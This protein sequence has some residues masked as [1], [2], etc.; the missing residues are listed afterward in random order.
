LALRNGADGA[1]RRQNVAIFCGMLRHFAAFPASFGNIF[2][3]DGVF[4]RKRR[5]KSKFMIVWRAEFWL[6]GHD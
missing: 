3:P 1:R 2:F 4:N 5:K 6:A